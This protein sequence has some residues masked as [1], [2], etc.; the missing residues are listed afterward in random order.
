MPQK[1]WFLDDEGVNWWTLCPADLV[2][3][4]DPS[5]K[6]DGSGIRTKSAGHQVSEFLNYKIDLALAESRNRPSV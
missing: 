3:I 6:V 5:M 4:P 1:V 2:R